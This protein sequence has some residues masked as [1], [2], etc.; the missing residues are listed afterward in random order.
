MEKN[1]WFTTE[2]LM[3]RWG[4]NEPTLAQYILDE[5]LPTYSLS[6]E[7]PLGPPDWK[8][9][10]LV[11]AKGLRVETPLVRILRQLPILLFRRED[12]LEFEKKHGLRVDAK[13]ISKKPK[14]E[15]YAEVK[16]KCRKK[17]RLL[18]KKHPKIKLKDMARRREIKRICRNDFGYTVVEKRKGADPTANRII[19]F[20]AIENWINNLRPDYRG[21]SPS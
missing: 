1:L 14:Q 4:I 3:N 15:R 8:G 10:A 19:T 20:G 21:G 13:S 18:W 2:D 7:G 5:E 12:V 17:A 16:E 11:D 9:W 6:K